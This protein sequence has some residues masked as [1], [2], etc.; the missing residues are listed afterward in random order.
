MMAS[1]NA[2][3]LRSD[4]V[5]VPCDGMRRAM[6]A[7][8]VGDDVID[9]DPT[10]DRLEKMI[11]ELLGMEAAIFMPSGSMANQIAVRIHCK[12]GDEFICEE[13]CHIYNYEQGAYAQ[14]SGVAIRTI[15][16][17]AGVLT[18]DHLQGTVRP[19]NE[20]MVRTRLL[21]LE[22]TH[23][24]AAGRIQPFDVVADVTSWARD[25]GLARHLD[26]ARFFNAVVGSAIPADAWA[27]MFDTVSV[28]FSKGLGAP[29]GSALV[30]TKEMVREARHHRKCFGGGMRQAGIIA[31]GAV[32]ALEHNIERLSHDHDKARRLAAAIQATDGISLLSEHVDS[33]MVIFELADHLPAAEDFMAQLEARGVRTLNTGHRRVRL[34]THLNVSDEQIDTASRILAETV[35]ACG[36]AAV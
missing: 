4:T 24:R 17:D 1:M 5:T 36:K 31:A 23:N 34:V 33:N 10:I 28:C 9:V 21:C 27:K 25:E 16:G 19:L 26:G 20:H 29:V 30:G 2:I 7:A 14:L 6:A 22:N 3:D 35:S 11:A 32:Y 15:I 18:R 12:P 8:P 13:G